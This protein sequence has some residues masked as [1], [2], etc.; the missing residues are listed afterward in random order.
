MT[1][2]R[3]L[4]LPEVSERLGVPL[5]TLYQWRYRRVGLRGIKIGRHVRIR[6]SELERFLDA[7]TDQQPA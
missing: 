7:C 1:V 4:T 6:E 5:S 3:L 2:D